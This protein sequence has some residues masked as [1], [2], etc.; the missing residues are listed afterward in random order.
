[1]KTVVIALL[2]TVGFSAAADKS[3]FE[4]KGM[5]CE[6]C[7]AKIKSAVT[8]MDGVS[9]LSVSNKTGKASVEFDARKTSQDKILKAIQDTGFEASA[10]T[11]S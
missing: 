4:V 3:C 5:T 6:A 11:C 10:G 9:S 1:M 8:K 7:E 2:M